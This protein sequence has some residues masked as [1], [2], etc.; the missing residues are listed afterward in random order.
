M[1]EALR[2]LGRMALENKQRDFLDSLVLQLTT[3]KNTPKPYIVF[4]NFDT[5]TTNVT[6]EIP[7]EISE[8]ILTEYLWV[9]N[10]DGANSPQWYVT[11][12]RLE[13]LL[14]QTIPNLIDKLSENSELKQVLECCRKS[15]YVDLG[16]Q[17]GQKERY[18]YIFDVSFINKDVTTQEIYQ[19]KNKDVKKTVNE[20]T[21][22]FYDYLKKEM[23]LTKEDAGLFTLL[24]D[25]TPI[26]LNKEYRSLVSYEKVDA[27]FA[28][29]QQGVCGAC[30]LYKPVTS[31]TTRLK[32][33]YYITDKINF[34]HG[35]DKNFSTNLNLCPECY[36]HLLAAETLVMK[37]LSVRI[38]AGA[39]G[40]SLYI[41]PGFLFD[42]KLNS[43]TLE[44]WLEDIELNFETMN[45]FNKKLTDLE[46]RFEDHIEHKA[47]DDN[48]M[49]NFLFYQKSQAELK[50]LDL[51]QDVPPSRLTNIKKVISEV[52]QLGNR[53]L[54]ESR[55][56]ILD[57]NKIYYLFPPKI[58]KR[59]IVQYREL[60][61]VF[62]SIFTGK[63][64][65]PN[66]VMKE[67][68]ELIQLHYYGRY[69]QYKMSK[70]NDPDVQFILAILR[71]NLFLVY[72]KKL[73][74]MNRGG[75]YV[76][77]SAW[78]IDEDIKEYIREVGFDECQAGLFLL[79]YLLGEVANAQYKN[80]KES[81]PI[82]DKLNYQGMDLKRIQILSLEIFEKLQQYKKLDPKVE[83]IHAQFKKIMD[84]YSYSDGNS[85]RK[86]PL[87]HIENVFYILSGYAFITH[88]IIRKAADKKDE[89]GGVI[90]E[91]SQN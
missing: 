59:K 61:H 75:V 16:K 1:I 70:P 6:L 66:L 78:C 33:K 35:L 90:N 58:Q 49:L 20:V 69:E 43:K 77:V 60:L 45:D 34:A 51:I 86:W 67:F 8:N 37:Y 68:L 40:L 62:E 3:P 32:F 13:Y 30:G 12:D 28:K 80:N 84:K 85:D 21:K 4:I 65:D 72:A 15:F 36:K 46:K 57:F 39:G 56:W 88:R 71:A 23:G 22:I 17:D 44:K 42:F 64:L 50:V 73:G 5:R 27:L 74:I 2:E 81:K 7:K 14:S 48:Y 76:D 55:N 54:G 38:G 11:T 24:I 25:D 9:G 87:D 52:H 26:A 31:N 63:P 83:N 79:G 29:A 41:I 19:Q 18:R 91:Q 82:L 53:M 47:E 89:K 10:A